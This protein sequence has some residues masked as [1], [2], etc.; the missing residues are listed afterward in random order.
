MR[1]RS[2]RDVQT[3]T[4][5]QFRR[6][7][8]FAVLLLCCCC[9]MG[10]ADESIPA[11]LQLLLHSTVRIHCG[12][13]FSSG[14]IISSSGHVLTV[15]HGLHD[16]VATIGLVLHDG[17]QCRAVRKVIDHDRDLAVLQI[18]GNC[19][20]QGRFVP[21]SASTIES[22]AGDQVLAS[23]WPVAGGV[24]QSAQL[25]IGSLQNAQAAS[26][27]T[28]CLLSTGDSGGP[29]LN[30]AGQL[31]G[32]HRR[33]GLGTG[34]NYHIS[35]TAIQEWFRE[36][37]ELASL[38]QEAVTTSALLTPVA[39]LSRTSLDNIRARLMR[40]EDVQQRS[41]GIGVL[42]DQAKLVSPGGSSASWA[43]GSTAANARL[44][45]TPQK[46][47]RKQNLQFYSTTAAV[48]PLPLI[49]STTAYRGQ[50]VYAVSLSVSGDQLVI[51]GPGIVSAV[52]HA[53]PSAELFLGFRVDADSAGIL[54]TE[55]VP[56]SPAQESGLQADDRLLKIE[57][58]EIRNLDAMRTSLAGIQPGDVISLTLRRN[59]EDRQLT[60]RAG[61]NPADLFDH[62]IYLD[63]RAGPLSERR[64]GLIGMICHD[65]PVTPEECGGLLVTPSGQIV[66]MNVA[67][68]A[69]QCT[70]TVPIP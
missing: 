9:R 66:G 44:P 7:F 17:S 14:V 48:G 47:L 56:N 31:I 67:R 64:T 58:S 42:L 41:V 21:I 39:Q 10:V 62:R 35:L 68:V 34:A 53:E 16:D 54:V 27:Q 13:D 33:I 19:T 43:T 59:D 30:A 45:L 8:R 70:L 28:S 22:A 29:L 12:T 61:H 46:T 23:G 15:A 40:L 69:R 2:R 49:T 52:N 55:V 63:G 24:Q 51:R 18:T 4:R 1:H 32:V 57:H 37:K 50:I 36:Q 6:L 38:L 5:L 26:L 25:R 3:E 11:G 65:I 60:I 20:V